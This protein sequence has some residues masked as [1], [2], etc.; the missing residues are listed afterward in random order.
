MLHTD[1]RT[2]FAITGLFKG[3]VI[4][5]MME[6]MTLH[7]IPMRV[8][9]YVVDITWIYLTGHILTYN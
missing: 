4:N 5:I 1:I 9:G 3:W 6:M 2:K 7:I 8:N